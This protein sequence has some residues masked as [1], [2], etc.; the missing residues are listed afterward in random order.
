MLNFRSLVG[1]PTRPCVDTS[2]NY[3]VKTDIYDVHDYEQDPAIFKANYDKLMT[4]G[5]L[6]DRHHLRWRYNSRTEGTR[7]TW[8]GEPVHVSEYGGIGIQVET[9]EQ[10]KKSWSYGNAARSFEEFYA[11]YKGLTDAL[12]DN[13]KI[14]GFCYTQLTDVEQEKNGLFTYENRTPKFDLEIISRI[15]KRKAA[16]EEE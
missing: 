1:C 14:F 7:Q 13:P 15:N 2:G 16:C 11:R 6:W 9:D 8:Q 4:E 10:R 3:H 5:T 12:L